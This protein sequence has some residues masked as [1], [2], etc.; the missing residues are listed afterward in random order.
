MSGNELKYVSDCI[1]TNWISSAGSYLERFES[2][3]AKYCGQR[4]GIG[5]C[6]GTAALE[7]A[8]E[9]CNFPKGS[10]I[11]LP[12]F[13]IISCAQ[14]IVKNN[15]VPVLVDC[16]P[17]TY[18]MDVSQIGAKLTERT[19][20]IM[21]VHIYGNPCDMDAVMDIAEK[22]NLMVI[23]DAA[24]VHGGEYLS[25]KV[26]EGQKESLS[27]GSNN[28]KTEHW[29]KC[30]S[31]GHMSCFSFY[32]NKNITTG[33]GGMVLTSDE[34]IAERLRSHRNL[35]F[36]K[37]PRFLH[38]EIGSNYRMTNIQ[39]ALGLAQLEYIDNTITRKIDMA[40]KYN[41]SLKDLPLQLPIERKWAKNVI[42]MYSV[43]LREEEKTR[44]Y[45]EKD[46]QYKST[47][48]YKNWPSYKI[49]EKISESGIGTR[50]FFIGIHEQPVLHEMGLFENE[51]YPVTNKITRTGFYLP[52]GQAITD[53]Q[54]EQVTAIFKGLF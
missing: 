43:L 3:W 23:E 15:C 18:C 2:E 50:P 38:Y 1:N 52:S 8:V 37:S 40:K 31:F 33:E 39:A 53:D 22:H 20:A 35:C 9:V 4:Y 21:P 30:G 34:K 25:H 6:N 47:G 44:D 42:W 11:I 41:R 14:A 19:V 51:S 16:D 17:E 32:A 27:K 12:S 49:M 10:E 48:E 46:W 13:T 7:L 24:E 26:S 54:I 28:P 36:L 5:V 45:F 29:R